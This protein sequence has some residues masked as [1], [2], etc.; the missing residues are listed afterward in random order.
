MKMNLVHNTYRKHD[1]KN[2]TDIRFVLAIYFKIFVL[3]YP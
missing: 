3:K 2:P 1:K